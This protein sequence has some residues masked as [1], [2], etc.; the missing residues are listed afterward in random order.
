MMEAVLSN[1]DHPEYGVATIPLPIPR[2]QYDHCVALLEALEIGDASEADC[3]VDSLDSAWPVL[4]RLV[5]TKV[6]LDELD[7][8]AKRL[9]SFTVG[10]FSQFQAMVE[11]LHLTSM[12]DL[13]N[14][15]FC[16][17]QAT[18]I[19]DFTNLK[20][21]GRDH[22]MNIH[23]GCASMEELEQLDGVETA[24]LLIEDNE[25]TITRYGVVY[26]NGMQLSQL[27]DGKHLPCYHYEADMT[28]VGISSRWE[29]ENS[30]NVTW[31][32]LPASKGQIERAMQRSGIADPKD[33]R[34]F[35]AD[36]SFPEE[37]DVALDFRCDN[38]YELNELALVA[39]KLSCDDRRKLG[40]AVSMAKPECASQIRRLAENLDLFEFAPGAHTPEEYGKYMIQRSGHFEY[41][42]NLDEFYDYERYGLQHM[43]YGQTLNVGRVMTPTLAM[44]VMREAAIRSFVPEPFYKVQ[45]VPGGFYA[46]GERIREKDVAAGIVEQCRNAA[47]ATVIKVEQKEK[48]EKAPV[49]YDLTSLQRDANRL[50]GF[51]AQQ[52]LDYT[53]SLYEKKLVTYPRT[54]SRYLTDD[55]AGMLPELVTMVQQK[56]GICPDAPAPV[57]VAQ[58][59]NS[60]K[61]TDHHAIIPT[62][63]LAGTDLSELPG[64]EK[65]VLDLVVL[66]L[67]YAVG[68][69]YRYLESVIEM[70]CAGHIFKAKGKSVI[71][72]GWKAYA[73]KLDEK[74]EAAIVLPVL[75]ELMELPLS[76]VEL[77]EG[78]TAPPKHFTEDLLLSAMEAAGADE[79]PKEAERRGIG[80]PATRASIIEKLVQKGFVERRGDKKTKILVP[81]SKGEALVTVVPEQIQ[82]P[83]M[84]AEWEEKL[85]EMERGS[86]ASDR[87][88]GEITAMVSDLVQNSKRVDGAETLLPQKGAV[89]GRCPACGADVL[90]RTKG[91]FCSNKECRFALWKDN[92]YF[93]SI[94][95]KLTSGI[96]EKLITAGCVKLKGC[97]S[98]KTGKSFDA[99]LVLSTGENGQ[100]QFSMEFERKKK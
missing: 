57:N 56:C 82:S 68:E 91:Y 66:R 83:S 58:V 33:M 63:T 7:Y 15:T 71:S 93:D 84:T 59:I 64:G 54:D 87:F 53:Q 31:I 37:V 86:Y 27:Y 76:S 81:T 55:M 80:T 24:V 85:L 16:C 65:A 1:A 3:R 75:E 8:L 35:M 51:T 42:P 72:P 49:L 47:K 77:K 94:G 95:K 28:V 60:K 39:D 2:N 62:K 25:G 96:A 34:L 19:T 89:I 79:I 44:V 97:K 78:K 13:I 90:D 5:S 52:T 32:Y 30:R 6:N 45:I 69:P 10:E 36:S 61:V 99:T 74:E 50:L 73:G 46:D 43:G 20:E 11:K 48:A 9:D 38:I 14:L 100:A 88:M 12:K 98:A 41:D 40:A 18:V 17:Q 29:P 4:N 23:G 67:I 92:R 26:D 22:Y 21:V 70:D